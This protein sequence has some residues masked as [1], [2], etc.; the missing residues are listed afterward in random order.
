[1]L[2]TEEFVALLQIDTETLEGW[3]AIGW[4]EPRRHQGRPQF[5]DIDLARASLIAELSGAMGVNAEGIDIILHLLEQL[6]GL[7]ARAEDLAAALGEQPEDLRRQL[8][9]AASDRRN[10]TRRDD[11]RR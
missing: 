3:V 2:E 4:L 1:M 10:L 9:A 8:L 11:R 5:S 6:H 7:Q